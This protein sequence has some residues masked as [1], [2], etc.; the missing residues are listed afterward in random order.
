[1][2]QR[3]APWILQTLVIACLDLLDLLRSLVF[4]LIY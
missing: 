4:A 2:P 1:M 3:V